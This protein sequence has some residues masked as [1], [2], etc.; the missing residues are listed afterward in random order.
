MAMPDNINSLIEE[1]KN[2]LD[3][4]ISL[5]DANIEEKLRRVIRLA[6]PVAMMKLPIFH[7]KIFFTDSYHQ[8]SH[9]KAVKQP[10]FVRVRKIDQS[11]HGKPIS[12]DEII[13]PQPKYSRLGRAN[14]N[15]NP[16]F[17][18]SAHENPEMAELAALYEVNA[19]IGEQYIVSYWQLSGQLRLFN[20]GKTVVTAKHHA[21]YQVDE[22]PDPT[23]PILAEV[24]CSPDKK[25]Y[26]I[27]SMLC[28]ILLY[29]CLYDQSLIQGHPQGIIYPSIQ[30]DGLRLNAKCDNYAITPQALKD[31]LVWK[32]SDFVTIAQDAHMANGVVHITRMKGMACE[33]DED[34]NMRL[35]LENNRGFFEN[36]PIVYGN[37]FMVFDPH[38][39]LVF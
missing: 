25:Y 23:N 29:G 33:L 21:S 10:V 24:F 17:Y 15:G 12:Y 5:S 19:R 35:I 3:S 13:H 32:R 37:S 26:P 1:L 28:E 36:R 6:P 38:G 20:L 34:N 16:I 39:E 7:K 11:F 22:F 30:I 31:S 9:K 4:G 14:R 8:A 18:C 2:A 27:T